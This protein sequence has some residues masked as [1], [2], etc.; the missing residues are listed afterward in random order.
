M[1]RKRSIFI[2]NACEAMVAGDTESCQRALDH[3]R[4]S[5]ARRP[6]DP[7][8]HTAC[9]AQLERLQLLAQASCD[10]IVASQNWL[11]ELF[12]LTGGLEVYDRTGR[13]RVDTGLAA[14]ARRF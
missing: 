7:E 14:P 1:M 6:L 2:E 5:I 10:G 3:F 13:Q 9:G 12:R 8:E 11:N 4:D